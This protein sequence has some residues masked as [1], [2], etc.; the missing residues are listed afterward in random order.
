MQFHIFCP[1]RHT[2]GDKGL[3]VCLHNLIHTIKHISL[4]KFRSATLCR[5]CGIWV[6]SR[7]IFR[8]RYK[9]LC[10]HSKYWSDINH[11]CKIFFGHILIQLCH[12]LCCFRCPRVILLYQLMKLTRKD[13]HENL[14]SNSS[15]RISLLNLSSL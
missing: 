3:K 6:M 12:L 2:R 10:V 4:C 5:N 13:A 9:N 1:P 8:L 7:K 15:S 14:A 11:Q